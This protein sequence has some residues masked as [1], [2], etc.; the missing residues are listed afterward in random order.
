MI[1]PVLKTDSILTLCLNTVSN[2]LRLTF[3]ILLILLFLS[4]ISSQVSKYSNEFLTIGVGA[5]ALGMAGSVVACV[6]DVTA[7]Y[8]NPAGLYKQAHASQL[9]LMHNEYFAGIA[10]YD[11][12]AFSMRLDEKSLACISFIRFG[13]DDIL[14]T[15]DL[16]D[17]DGNIRYDRIAKFS[18]ADYGIILS[19]ARDPG[20]EGLSFGGNL[21]LIY[22]K[23]GDFANAWGFGFDAGARYDLGEWHFGASARDVTSTFNAWSFNT[24]EMTEVFA[25]TGNEL[26]EN[27]LELTMPRLILGGAREVHMSEKFSILAEMDADITFD[28]KRHVLMAT[29]FISIDPH[30]GFE[31]DYRKII[32]FRL[33]MGNIQLIPDFDKNRSFDFQP[34][35]GLGVRLKNFI[36][37]YALTDLGNQSIALYSNVFS[38]AYSF[39]FPAFDN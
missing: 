8:W 12:G 24:S 18:A 22:R 17:A 21:K 37:D 33:G 39:D 6:D 32:F 1:S 29:N 2:T 30:I 19:Y 31:F 27:S 3:S 28:G 14:N 11:F 10:K 16:I 20:I 23:T 26:P 38:L 7:G 15:L 34:A 4:P 36:I 13:I 35:L 9:G 5:R 25:I